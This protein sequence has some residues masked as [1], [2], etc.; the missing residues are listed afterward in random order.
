MTSES[1]RPTHENARQH[2]PLVRYTLRGITTNH[3]DGVNRAEGSKVL[4]MTQSRSS[5]Q[6]RWRSLRSTDKDS[7]RLRTKPQRSN[8]QCLVDASGKAQYTN[9]LEF[10]D[11][12]TSDAF[13]RAVIDAG[14]EIQPQCLGRSVSRRS[15][16]LLDYADVA[17]KCDA[18]TDRYPWRLLS[19][20]DF[21]QPVRIRGHRWWIESSIDRYVA[22]K[23]RI[24]GGRQLDE[25]VGPIIKHRKK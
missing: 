4:H 25:P 5:T 24:Q 10:A 22:K 23:L 7:D 3:D 2:R 20:P 15:V 13:S 18:F 14:S 16:V 6:S 17:H 11:R 9:I 21:P 12:P 1:H 19:E 8:R